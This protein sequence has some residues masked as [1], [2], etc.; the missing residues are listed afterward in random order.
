M[1][2]FFFLVK[3]E[4]PVTMIGS[5]YKRTRVSDGLLPMGMSEP[6]VAGKRTERAKHT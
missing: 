5:N 2:F 4:L 1:V 6:R 3:T